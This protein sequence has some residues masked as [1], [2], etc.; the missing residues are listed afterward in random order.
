VSHTYVD[1]SVEF[2]ARK[3]AMSLQSSLRIKKWIEEEEIVFPGIDDV[4]RWFK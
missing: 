2:I 4:P 1:P 3:E